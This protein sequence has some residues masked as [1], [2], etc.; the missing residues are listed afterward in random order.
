M[1]KQQKET[2]KTEPIAEDSFS[3]KKETEWENAFKKALEDAY[4]KGLSHGM[5]TMCGLVLKRMNTY[6]KQKIA[7]Q[8]QLIILRKWCDHYLGVINQSD[9]PK[10]NKERQNK[11]RPSS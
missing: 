11:T 1:T 5:K 9:S 7:P 3:I 4:I 10:E 2:D 6:Q 8:K